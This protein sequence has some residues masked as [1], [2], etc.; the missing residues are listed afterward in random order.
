LA[1]SCAGLSR[2]STR[3]HQHINKKDVDG[4]DSAFGRPGHDAEFLARR[5][6]CA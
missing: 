1:P 6:R 3:S 2:A 5:A 4:R